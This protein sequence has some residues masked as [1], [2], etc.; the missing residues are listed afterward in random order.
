MFCPQCLEEFPWHV[1]VCPTCDVDTVDR[2]P[3]PEPTP[4]VALVRVLAIVD[5]GII[6][7]AKSLLE[8]EA[9]DYFVKGDVL[10]DPFAIGPAEFWVREHDADRARELLEGLTAAGRRFD[11]WAGAE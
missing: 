1:M 7:V 4:D 5:V 3:G 2:L 8:G 11:D 6:A 9:I 10:Q